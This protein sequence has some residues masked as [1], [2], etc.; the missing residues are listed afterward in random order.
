MILIDHSN[1]DVDT[2]SITVTGDDMF[3]Q[4]IVYYGGLEPPHY[5]VP[6]IQLSV[7]FNPIDPCWEI[8]TWIIG[9]SNSEIYCDM[10]ITEYP[11]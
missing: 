4:S 9:I 11:P 3:R 7:D 8:V 2:P 6:A 10:V 5:P 1:R